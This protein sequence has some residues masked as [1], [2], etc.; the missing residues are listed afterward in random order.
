MDEKNNKDTDQK[1]INIAKNDLGEEIIIHD[2]ERYNLR[3]RILKLKKNLK[4]KL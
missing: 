4:E 2:I 3:Y 1:T